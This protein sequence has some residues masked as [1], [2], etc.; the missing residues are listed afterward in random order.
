M[1]RLPTGAKT[2]RPDL[3]D[4]M[5]KAKPYVPFIEARRKA[6]QSEGAVG[7]KLGTTRVESVVRGRHQTGGN[8]TGKVGWA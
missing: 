2:F 8:Q 6:S 3:K 4:E 7:T 5:N 1:Q